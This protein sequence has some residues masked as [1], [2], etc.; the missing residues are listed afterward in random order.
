MR[1]NW[2]V[3]SS[4]PARHHHGRQRH[5]PL[6]TVV[7]LEVQRQQWAAATACAQQSPSNLFSR[8]IKLPEA[9]EDRSVTSLRMN[10]VRIGLRVLSRACA[11]TFDLAKVAVTGQIVRTVLAV[12]ERYCHAREQNSDAAERKWQDRSVRPAT[13][14]FSRAVGQGFDGQHA[15]FRLTARS[16]IPLATKKRLPSR[17]IQTILTSNCKLFFE[18]HLTRRCAHIR[19]RTLGVLPSSEDYKMSKTAIQ[20]VV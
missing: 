17:Q 6:D 11:V 9:T 7:M 1:P 20:N 2:A 10:P 18:S 13:R 16:P 14:S 8:C 12:F 5:L 15:G 4:Q 19:Y 3:H